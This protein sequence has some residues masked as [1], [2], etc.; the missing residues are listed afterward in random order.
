M[1][2]PIVAIV[3]RQNVGKSTLLNRMAGKQVAIVSDIPGTTRDRVVANILWQNKEF[4]LVDTGGLDLK[5][6]SDMAQSVNQQVITAMD[7]ADLIIFLVDIKDGAIPADQ[8]ITQ[9]MRSSKKPVLLVA[10]KAD[11]EKL[12]INAVDFFQLGLGAPI[13]ISAYHGLGISDLMDKIVSL[14][15]AAPEVTPAEEML[16]IAIVGRPN[17]GKSMLLNVLLGE[18]RA[19]VSNIPGTTRDALDTILDFNGQSV[20][21]IDTAGI[22][23]RGRIEQGIENYSV[24]R[25][26]RA[27]SRSDVVLLVLDA[28]ELVAAQDMHIAGY[29]QQEARGVIL[30]VNKCDLTLDLTQAA[31]ESFIRSK[32]KFLSYAPII[33]ISALLKQ[34]TEKII[35]MAN[36]IYKERFKR[37]STSELNTQIQRIAA[38][39]TPPRS[40]T[41]QLSI[42][43]ATQAETNPPTF[44]FF[45]ND[46][47]LVHFSYKRYI[48][49]GL[50]KAFG[51]DGTP[52][53]LVFKPRGEQ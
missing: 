42:F 27:V 23:R 22:R 18:E 50:R 38:A 45:V 4:M 11:N 46:V 43:Y 12:N 15:P 14:L 35:P 19:I 31:A 26:F 16:K 47:K 24:L 44:V 9:L 36:Q 34:G 33:Q 20:L 48:E 53:Q 30:L 17:A 6:G 7:G 13:V 41:K 3:G 39:H 29:I 37:I 51:F 21:I 10:N 5:P 32:F 8:E 49:N 52:I 25:S 40:G 28:T 1:I 2:K